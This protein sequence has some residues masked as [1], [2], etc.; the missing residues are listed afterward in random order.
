MKKSKR[1]LSVLLAIVI[2]TSVVTGLQLTV[3][4][5]DEPTEAVAETVAESEAVTEGVTE[6]PTVVTT[7]GET[8]L[9][10]Q[11][12]TESETN[13]ETQEPT[14][15]NTKVGAVETLYKDLGTT[16]E[17]KISWDPVEDAD[18]YRIYYKNNDIHDDFKMLAS[19]RGTAFTLKGLT[20]TTPYE[21]KVTA[22]VIERGK[23]YQ[24]DAVV[25]KTGTEVAAT[26]QPT[27]KRSSTMIEISWNKNSNADGYRIYRQDASTN[28]KLVLYHTIE[29]N[30]VTSYTDNNVNQGR[31]YNYQVKAYREMYPDITYLGKGETL[32]TLA[33]LCAPGTSATSQL[34]RV[35]LWWN[36]NAYAKG[37]DITYSTSKSG[38]FTLLKSTTNTFL[39]TARLTTGQTYY[40][41]VY[42][43]TY[44]GDH[45]VM[46]TYKP[47]EITVTD[48]AYGKTI[49]TTYIEISIRQQHMWFYINGELYVETPV[50]T[51]NVGYYSTPTGAYNIYQRLSP[52]TLTG[53]TWSSYVQYWMAFTY[54]GCG[55]HD[56]SWRSASEYGGTTYMGNGSHGCVNTPLAAVKKIYGKAAIGTHVVVY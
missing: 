45:K 1:I 40:F 46:G 8:A 48:K 42:P 33:G 27:L 41:R 35:S 37:Y 54:S 3:N 14:V 4:A 10:T 5:S 9:P 20:H 50:V 6:A 24:G 34:R 47:Y 19:T 52:A 25:G 38:P 2:M 21:F 17:L 11:A 13:A 32:R 16:S 44:V 18:G 53:P 28:G 15:D 31:A 29:D 12:E 49:G 51:G 56:A 36:K 23:I 55:I 30:T 26:N 22:F 39:N 43:Y 7:E